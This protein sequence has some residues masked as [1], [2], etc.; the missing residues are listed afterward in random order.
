MWTINE[1]RE[2]RDRAELEANVVSVS[3]Q[4][5]CA[6]LDLAAAAERLEGLTSRIERGELTACA[7][8]LQAIAERTFG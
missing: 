4:W 2:V 8:P 1:L 5:Q 7:K 3:N 6:C